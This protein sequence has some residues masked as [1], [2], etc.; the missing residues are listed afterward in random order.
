[1][2][3]AVAPILYIGLDVH[4]ESITIAVLPSGAEK[5]TRIDRLAH[6]FKVVRR[7]LERLDRLTACAPVMKRVARVTSWSGR[8]GRGAWRAPS[9]P[10][11]S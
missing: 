11:R 10:P 1:M 8:C 5:P 7:Y 4:K 2:S 9:S 6:D 3:T